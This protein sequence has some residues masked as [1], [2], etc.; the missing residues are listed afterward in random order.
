MRAGGVRQT[1]KVGNHCTVVN[2][3]PAVTFIFKKD[4]INYMCPL[5]HGKDFKPVF[6]QTVMHY[7]VSF[8]TFELL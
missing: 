4:I 1:K 7:G 5:N 2:S 6:M 8:I 3:F